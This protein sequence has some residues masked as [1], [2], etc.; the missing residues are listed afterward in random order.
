MNKKNFYKNN[1]LVTTILP[2]L[3]LISCGQKEDLPMYKNPK[4]PV[5]ERVEDL[6]ARMT[7]EEKI[8]QLSGLGFETKE[9][10]RLGIPVLK[11]ADGPVG[12]RRGQAT[13]FPAAVGIAATWNTKLAEQISTVIAKEAK[14]K[15]LNYLLGPCVNI[16]RHPLGG[17]NFESYGEDPYLASRM[18]VAFVK[19]IQSQNVLAAIKHFACNNQEWERFKLDVTLEE[20]AFRE[21][22]LPAFKAAVKEAD[23]WTVMAAYNKLWGDYCSENK[24]LLV[25]ILKGEW[26]FRGFVVSDWGATHS[27]V[28]AANYGLD[29]EMPSGKFFNEKLLEAVKKG[30]VSEAAIDD[31]IRRLMRVRFKAGLFDQ[32]PMIDETVLHREEHKQLALEAAKQSIVLLKNERNVLPLDKNKIKSIALLGPNAAHARIGGGGSS[33]VTPFYAVSPLQGLEKAVG[34]NIKIKYALGIAIRGDVH[35]LNPEYMTPA[36]TSAGK[37]GLW[38]EY[39]DNKELKGKP[40]FTRLDK[41]INFNWGYDLPHEALQKNNNSRGFSIRWT[42]KLLPPKTG[43]YKLGVAHNH[44]LRLYLDDQLLIDNWKKNRVVFKSASIPLTAG[45]RCDLRIEYFNAGGISVVI[46]G[47]SL[48]DHDYLAEAVELA[49]H[50]DAAVIVA[51][52]HNRFESEGHDR[53][54]LELP[55]QDVLIQAVAEANPNTIVVLNTGSPVLMNP[56]IDKTA[57]LVQ[58]WYPGQE[59]G[60]AI[61]DVLV[62]NTNPSGKLPFSLI[63]KYEDSPAFKDY[64]DKSLKSPYPEG[65]FVGYRYLDKYHIEPLFP[66]GHGLSYSQFEYSNL[67]INPS[68][69]VGEGE[70][71]FLFTVSVDIRNKGKRKGAE[72]VQVYL[73]DKECSVARPEKELKGFAKV[74]LQPGE[75]KTVTIKLNRDAFAFYEPG[76]DQ[77]VVEPGEFEILV[78][79]SSKDIYFKDRLVIR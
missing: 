19:G 13:A 22:Y 11:M 18:A 9:N 32:Q 71:G 4:L 42:G 46:F 10:K 75:K 16:Q 29:L 50:S 25:D 8:E 66:F 15:G 72:V 7:L 17:R 43:V 45:Q 67:R 26:G 68:T 40:V 76:Q 14:S 79:S 58:A 39:F 34:N 36:N 23:A 3:L 51:G 78:G 24:H 20:R 70:D 69:G 53:R 63:R 60:N 33:Q 31:K 35:P 38:G 44:G 73:R 61:A 6:L 55:N 59:G 62:G 57:A 77:W 64:R 12:V 2:L 5:E 41:E 1:F 65:I 37:N 52:L 54:R 47:W 49:K 30:E 28:K 21:I 48:P 74:F 27:T 56:W